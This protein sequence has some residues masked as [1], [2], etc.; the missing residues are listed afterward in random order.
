MEAELL[1]EQDLADRSDSEVSENPEAE[2]REIAPRG[3]RGE[4]FSLGLGLR[5]G[6]ED[7]YRPVVLDLEDHNL[8][9]ELNR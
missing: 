4:A 3:L 5:P 6:L 2:L 1:I 7:L 9:P 8:V